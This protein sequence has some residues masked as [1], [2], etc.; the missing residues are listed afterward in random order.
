[1]SEYKMLE[2]VAELSA[3]LDKIEEQIEEQQ[4]WEKGWGTELKLYEIVS[5]ILDHLG[6]EPKLV[7]KA[8]EVR[9]AGE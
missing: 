6:M 8:K 2:K 4:W 3:R 7:M 1:M 9:K 5:L